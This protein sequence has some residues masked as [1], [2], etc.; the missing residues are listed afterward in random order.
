MAEVQLFIKGWLIGLGIAAP[1]GP[2]GVLCLRRTLQQGRLLGFVSGLGAATADAA[3]G[4]VAALGL[5]WLAQ[6]LLSAKDWLGIIGGI[7]I[8][9]LG[10]R[11]LLTKASTTQLD[12][13]PTH[14]TGDLFKAWASTFVITLTNPLTI[15]SFAAVFAGLGLIQ[16]SA[17]KSWTGAWLVLGVFIGSAMWWGLLSGLG[18]LFRRR[19]NQGG[20]TWINRGAGILLFAMGVAMLWGILA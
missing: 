10:I 18:G 5:S 7:F 19:L 2:V 17:V 13:S 3:Y 14:M 8:C 16:A 11:S 9:Y 12:A 4:M 6:A 20:L 15:L 1:V